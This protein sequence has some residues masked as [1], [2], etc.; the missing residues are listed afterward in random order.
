MKEKLLLYFHGLW[1]FIHI[2]TKCIEVLEDNSILNNG[3]AEVEVHALY[4]ILVEHVSCESVVV[5]SLA[6]HSCKLRTVEV[7]FVFDV[8]VE[9]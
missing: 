4:S 9:R 2:H 5:F 8:V 3:G 7:R 6:D 1:R